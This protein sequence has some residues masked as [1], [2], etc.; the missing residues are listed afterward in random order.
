M[1]VA[2][3]SDDRTVHAA[4]TSTGFGKVQKPIH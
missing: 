2:T 4:G 3:V 1:Q